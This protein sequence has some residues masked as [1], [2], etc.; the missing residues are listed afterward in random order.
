MTFV[1]I[2]GAMPAANDKTSTLA[3]AI[4]AIVAEARAQV[5]AGREP[6]PHALESR[7]RSAAARERQNGGGDTVAIDEAERSAL[8]QLERVLSI[9]RARA[10]LA[11]KPAP[12]PAP[13]PALKPRRAV[14]RS[15][16]TITGNMEVRRQ[17]S[18]GQFLLAWD[19]V[20]A[21]ASWEVRISERKDPR[22]D[23]IVVDLKTLPA[24]QT[25]VELPLG[26]RGLRVHLLGR[27]RD[28]RLIQRAVIS[29]LTRDSWDERWQRRASAS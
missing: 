16:P 24:T 3:D 14:V 18:D 22:S 1:G 7:V 27:G 19:A 21:V 28:G 20:P 26:D 5:A 17:T 11:E 13:P 25:S 9:A 4:K 12:P 15:K 29:A 23:Y 2:L 8:R 10:R 6:D